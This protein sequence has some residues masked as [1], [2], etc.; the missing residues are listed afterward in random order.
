MSRHELMSSTPN[1]LDRQHAPRRQRAVASP[2]AEDVI[3]SRLRDIG[4]ALYEARLYVA[5]LRDGSQNGN[6]VAKH[7]AVPSSKAYAALEKLAVAGFVQSSRHGSST[8]WAALP[9]DELIARL[10]KQF[11]E[12][13]DFLA[14]ELP[15]V[16]VSR[17]SEPFLT[18]SG[19]IAMRDAAEAVIRASDVELHISCWEADL[20]VLW[21]PLV[22]AHERGVRVFGM[23][24][25]E[26]DPPPGLW[27]HHH[28]E[29]IVA[30]RVDGRLLALVGDERE[31]LIARI[32]H[33]GEANAVLSRNPV[34]TLIV[35]EY[36]HHDNVLQRAQLSMGFHEWDRW[37]QA[38]PEVR[39]EILG[40]GIAAPQSEPIGDPSTGH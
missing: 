4:F 2:L 28:Y 7:A 36:L 1:P 22:D 26:E 37:W 24:Y 25:G 18:V 9:S 11:N 6:E 5:L 31:A 38:D 35:R 39:A 8:L 16:Q 34:M 10:R 17:P 27:L 30:D 19:V 29:R 20:E 23:L 12:P 33:A 21:E 14:E 40:H 13:L 3:V 32:P 15:R